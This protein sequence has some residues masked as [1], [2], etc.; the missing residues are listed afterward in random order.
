MKYTITKASLFS[1]KAASLLPQRTKK[2]LTQQIT[3]CISKYPS[4]SSERNFNDFLRE[5]HNTIKGLVT[6]PS[7]TPLYIS[8]TTLINKHYPLTEQTPWGGVSLHYVS[9]DKNKI[10]KLLVIKNLVYLDLKCIKKA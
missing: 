6:D 1:P 7:P 8:E 2:L 9:V 5:L 3:S 4:L 10:K